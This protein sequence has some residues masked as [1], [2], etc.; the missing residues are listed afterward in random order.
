[1][2][3]EKSKVFRVLTLDGGGAKGFY[4]LGVLK[5]I[6]GM[7]ACPLYQRFDLVLA[8]CRWRSWRQKRCRWRSRC[9]AYSVGMA[10]SVIVLADGVHARTM[11]AGASNILIGRHPGASR[12]LLLHRF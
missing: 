3:A 7:I 2:N 6:E 1:M 4:T 9:G 8:P 10:G 11:A 12:G 5:E